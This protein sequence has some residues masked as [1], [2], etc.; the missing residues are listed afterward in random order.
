MSK[1]S[2]AMSVGE[3]VLGGFTLGR[4]PLFVAPRTAP[5]MV[6]LYREYYH[7]RNPL[8]AGLSTSPPGHALFDAEITDIEAFHR[9]EFYNDW[10]LPQGHV[11]GAGMSLHTTGGWRDTLMV[12]SRTAIESEA[13]L[14]LESLAPHLTRALHIN[15]ILRENHATSLAAFQAM[16]EADRAIFLVRCLL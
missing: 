14:L 4:M 3:A 11:A 12:T 7:A 1:I 16:E 8:P 6:R 5:E 13:L 9:S 10:C 15:Q 2:D